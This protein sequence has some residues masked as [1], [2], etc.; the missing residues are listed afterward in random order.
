MPDPGDLIPGTRVEGVPPG[1]PL[2][3]VSAKWHGTIALELTCG[4][5]TVARGLSRQ[6]RV[7]QVLPDEIRDAP[8]GNRSAL[9]ANA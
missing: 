2:T 8:D 5:P 6:R 9:L 3:V 1:R 7:R 4:R